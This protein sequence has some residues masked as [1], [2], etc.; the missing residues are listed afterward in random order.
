MQPVI[1]FYRHPVLWSDVVLL[2]LAL[3]VL[4]HRLR[5]QNNVQVLLVAAA[6][7]VYLVHPVDPVPAQAEVVPVRISITM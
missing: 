5:A 7:L 2:L 6:S 3:L 1:T 4:R